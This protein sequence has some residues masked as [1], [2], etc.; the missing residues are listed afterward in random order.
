MLRPA[1]ILFIEDLYRDPEVIGKY[2]RITGLLEFFDAT[3]NTSRCSYEG[4]F[5][6]IDMEYANPKGV[7]HLCQFQFIG[8]ILDGKGKLFPGNISVPFY[9]KARIARNV[10]GLDMDLFAKA[11]LSRRQF[12]MALSPQ[13]TS[14]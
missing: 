2:V 6:Y 10:D 7:F 9:L 12:I 4:H 11:I 5:V 3:T 1:E 13:H 8:E 14:S